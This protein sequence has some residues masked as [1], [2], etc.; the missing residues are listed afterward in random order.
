MFGVQRYIAAIACLKRALYLGPFEWLIA[1]NLGLVHLN[2]G[3]VASAFH[4][5]STAAN[6]NPG[7]AHSY[8]YLGVALAR[9]EDYEN[10]VAAYNKAISMNPT[11][12]LFH[13]NYATLLYNQGDIQASK[14]R[15]LEVN[16]LLGEMSS[17]AKQ[18]D[19]DMLE[20]QHALAQLLGLSTAV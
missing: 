13:L 15:W 1:Y 19:A 9:L 10:A 18:A 11:E 6:L 5:F 8:M 14:E 7:F 16:R 12:P 3:Q 2:T 17:E 20:Q 4:Y